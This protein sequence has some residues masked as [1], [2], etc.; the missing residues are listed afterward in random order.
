MYP[1]L[2]KVKVIIPA[3][4]YIHCIRDISHAA[5]VLSKR[6]KQQIGT[7]PFGRGT[8]QESNSFVETVL[9][10]NEWPMTFPGNY[11]AE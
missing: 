6:L 11:A 10:L 3:I 1:Q 2:H 9:H 4:N 8:Q 7:G 5:D